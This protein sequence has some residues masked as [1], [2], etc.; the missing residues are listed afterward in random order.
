MRKID[1]IQTAHHRKPSEVVANYDVGNPPKIGV[2]VVVKNRLLREI[3]VRLLR[4]Q[5]DIELIGEGGSGDLQ[6]PRGL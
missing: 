5:G 4:R 1:P 2:Y 3:L 6:R